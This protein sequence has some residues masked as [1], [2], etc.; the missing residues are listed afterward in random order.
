MLDAALSGDTLAPV[1]AHLKRALE[2]YSDRAAPD[3]RNSIKESISAVEAMAKIVAKDPKAT[4][5]DALKALEKRGQLHPALK[6]G[7]LKIYGYTNDEDGVRHAMLEDP[8]ITAADARFFLLACT[9]F[10]NYLK[11]QTP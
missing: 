2:L 5:A 7:F 6:D 11:A 3:Y 4:L 8:N 9:S 1:A 10:T